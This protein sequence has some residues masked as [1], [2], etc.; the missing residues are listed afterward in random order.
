MLK[1]FITSLLVFFLASCTKNGS[2]NKEKTEV[3]E[4]V[5]DDRIVNV[6]IWSNYL[7]ADII[8][9]F[10]DKTGIKIN[11]TNYSSNEELLAKLQAGATG[12]D[13]AV[14]SDYMILVMKKL[15]LLTPLNKEKLSNINALKPNLLNKYFDEGNI[16]SY[17]YGSGTTGIAINRSLYKGNIKSW[18]DLFSK[19]DLKGKFSLLDDS[20]EVLG[21]ALK[22]LGYSYNSTK[23]EE[24]E[25]AKKLLLKIKPKVKA[26][27]SEVIDLLV[28]GEVEVAQAY[29]CD[30]L[31]ANAKTGGKIDF[32]IPEEGGTSWMDGLVIPKGA[33]HIEEAHE[34]IN[35]MISA[36]ANIAHSVKMFSGPVVTDL[37]LM[38]AELQKDTRLIPTEEML[39]KCEMLQDLGDAASMWDKIWTEVKAE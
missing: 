23:K 13:V 22:S 28:S 9:E 7:D 29:S 32:I 1:I 24:L 15:E 21:A 4:R 30:A 37:S 19:E 34:L 38:P 33:L 3:K 31:Q 11:M 25:K 26:F 27:S 6:A 8:K 17:P 36:K 2:E 20:R 39:K 18:K 14:P 35:F 12:F 16:Y 5:V 10:Q